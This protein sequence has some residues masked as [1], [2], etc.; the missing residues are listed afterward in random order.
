[1]N[2]NNELVGKPFVLRWKPPCGDDYDPERAY[3]IVPASV[4]DESM[5][6]IEQ[7]LFLLNLIKESNLPPTNSAANRN[8]AYATGAAISIIGQVLVSLHSN[9]LG[10]LVDE[11]K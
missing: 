10:P 5:E 4:Y 3:K 6:M 2:S 7:G 11:S 8:I 9:A 1:M